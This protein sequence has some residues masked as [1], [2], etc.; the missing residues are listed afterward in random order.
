MSHVAMVTATGEEHGLIGV[1]TNSVPFDDFKNMTPEM[2][3]KCEAEKK[4]DNRLVKVRYINRRGNHERLTKPYCRWSGDPIKLY[5]LIPGREYEVPM[6][7]IKEVNESKMKRRSGLIS[8]NGEDINSNGSP[9]DQDQ[10]ME[11]LHELV[12]TKFF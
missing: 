6:G 10:D 2:K 5:H 8:V 12:P 9:L 1:L 3:K 7:L 11:P 4:E